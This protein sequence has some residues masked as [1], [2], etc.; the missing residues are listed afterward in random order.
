MLKQIQTSTKQYV[1]ETASVGP[2][3]TPN[4]VVGF[5]LS[6]PPPPTPPPC[7]NLFE[8]G[9]K[10]GRLPLL[11]TTQHECQLTRGNLRSL[12]ELFVLF[13]GWFSEVFPRLTRTEA[14]FS[15]M[16]FCSNQ[17][18]APAFSPR[19]CIGQAW[20]PKAKAASE[21]GSSAPGS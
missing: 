8:A 15:G 16:V 10:W 13:L 14:T 9:A 18:R 21:P 7:P 2:T 3:R 12:F 11:F 5:P 1:P 17:A 20:A 6:T 4:L 19:F